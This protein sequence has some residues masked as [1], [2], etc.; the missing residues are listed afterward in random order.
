VICV[1]LTIA[2]LLISATAASA[3]PATVR[4]AVNLRTTPGTDGAIVARIPA[5]SRVE[6]TNCR[7]WCAI[8]W[9]DKRGFV[10]ATSLD[11]GAT[12]AVVGK[13]ARRDPFATDPSNSSVPMSPGPYQAPERYYGPYFW[14]YGPTIGP[15]KS[16]SGLGF[17]GRW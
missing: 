6:T 9:Q 5:G 2:I 16:F 15:Y 17:R 14:S 8:A 10:I 7:D 4:S 12:P 13:A 1:R 3:E 11:R